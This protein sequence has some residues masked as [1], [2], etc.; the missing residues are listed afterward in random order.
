M[1]DSAAMPIA[2]FEGEIVRKMEGKLPVLTL[3][4]AEGYPRHHHIVM[5][6]EVRVRNINHVEDKHG[7]LVRHHNLAI[8]GAQI[9]ETFSPDSRPTSISGHTGGWQEELMAFLEGDAD[10][11]DFDGEQIPDRLR[12]MLKV[13]F[14]SRQPS[15]TADPRPLIEVLASHGD[16]AAHVEVD[17]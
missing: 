9:V 10:E 15:D 14:E 16:P 6:V 13:Y 4:M 17:F 1:T 3:D 11:L 12:E 7:D 2:E 8:V 5:E